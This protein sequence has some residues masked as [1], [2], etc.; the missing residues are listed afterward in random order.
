MKVIV[1]AKKGSFCVLGVLVP[2]TFADRIYG[3]N[4]LGKNETLLSIH[5][6][7]T[8]TKA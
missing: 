5:D 4:E 6:L 1:L 2:I 7:I 8:T 3:E